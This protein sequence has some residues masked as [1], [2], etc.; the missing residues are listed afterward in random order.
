MKKKLIITLIVLSLLSV[1]CGCA[2]GSYL[3]DGIKYANAA[4]YT[5]GAG[6]AASVSSIEIDWIA[7]AVNVQYGETQAVTFSESTTAEL[8]E[9]EVM[10]WWLDGATLHLKFAKSGYRANNVPQKTLT[11]TLP[12]SFVL[13]ELDIEAVSA[14]VTVTG[15][16]VAKLD[17]ETVSGNVTASGVTAA[18]ELDF[19]TVSGNVTA[20][21]SALPAEID[22][23][24]V[25]GDMTLM[26]EQTAPFYAEFETVSGKFTCAFGD[27]VKSGKKYTAGIVGAPCRIEAETVSGNFTIREKE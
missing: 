23:E 17:I 9:D 26:L 21:L 3:S 14:N 25:S 20:D 2:A 7:G 8:S 24:T 27:P 19:Q 13:S 10:H 22:C 4:N 15:I 11:L 12:Q 18:R 1:L 6:E 5:A 16:S